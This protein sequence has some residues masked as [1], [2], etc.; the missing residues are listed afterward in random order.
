MFEST[1]Q[2]DVR[3]DLASQSRLKVARSKC[4]H[5]ERCLVFRSHMAHLCISILSRTC[6]DAF[7]DQVRI[8]LG[9][10]CAIAPCAHSAVKP[11]VPGPIM[12]VIPVA[13]SEVMSLAV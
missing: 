12:L 9:P 10:S 4:R 7:S 8:V 1:E 11:R 2:T 3:I 6:E 5:S 13:R